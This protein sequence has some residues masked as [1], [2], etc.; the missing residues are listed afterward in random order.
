VL[1]VCCQV[2]LVATI[3]L[4]P[5]TVAAD[6]LANLPICHSDNGDGGSPAQP[7]PGQSGHDCVLCAIC[8]AHASP[9]ALLSPAPSPTAPR[10]IALIRH[11]AYHP[12]APPVHE[13]IAARPR[14]PPS[15]I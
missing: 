11:E 15:L 4:A 14:G 8:L 1:A 9:A 5:L 12:R 10:L 3:S 13:V 7:S 2:L 6:P